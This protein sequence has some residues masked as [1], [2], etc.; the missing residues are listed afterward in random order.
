MAVK[1]FILLSGNDIDQTANTYK[2]AGGRGQTGG[3][4][5]TVEPTRQAGWVIDIERCKNRLLKFCYVPATSAAHNRLLFLLRPFTVLMKQTRQAVHAVKQSILWA[6][7]IDVP[8][9]NTIIFAAATYRTK[10]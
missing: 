10:I 2:H 9:S 8:T 4:G 6:G 5:Q 3:P 7:Y 1:S